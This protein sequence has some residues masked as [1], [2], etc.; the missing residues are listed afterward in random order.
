M[1]LY[2]DKNLDPFVKR[3]ETITGAHYRQCKAIVELD[4][5]DGNGGRKDLIIEYPMQEEKHLFML[6]KDKSTRRD[7]NHDE[8][9]PI[10]KAIASTIRGV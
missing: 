1:T 10:A 6:M 3:I 7:I 4:V 2:K 8:K 5:S 9:F